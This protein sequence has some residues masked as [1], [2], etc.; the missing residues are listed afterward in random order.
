MPREPVLRNTWSI[1]EAYLGTRIFPRNNASI[2]EQLDVEINGQTRFTCNNYG[3]LYNTLFDYTADQDSLNLRKVG[4]N[5]DPSSK[6]VYNK[7]HLG[8][9]QEVLYEHRG[10]STGQLASGSARDKE[11]YVIRSWLGILNPSTPIIDTNILGSV[12]IKIRLAPS[13][14]IMLGDLFAE[15]PEHVQ[16]TMLWRKLDPNANNTSFTFR[17]SHPV[18]R[19]TETT[20]VII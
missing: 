6:F 10:Y 4:E 7:D 20:T 16:N 5:A 13:S 3:L 2:I 17:R 11:N 19:L 12:V 8:P 9:G 18:I 14:C 15:L 1:D